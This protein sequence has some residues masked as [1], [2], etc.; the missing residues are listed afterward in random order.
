MEMY[1]SAG[2]E[3]RGEDG[4]ARSRGEFHA[5]GG[6]SGV[7][8]PL[9]AHAKAAGR[10]NPLE[11][12]MKSTCINEAHCGDGRGVWSSLVGPL[13][14]GATLREMANVLLC[15]VADPIA[16]DGQAIVWSYPGHD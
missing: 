15:Q 6:T 5:E 1:W 9:V 10:M 7:Q 3:A 8:V 4:R 14:G 12:S 2:F 16:D 11:V 13:C